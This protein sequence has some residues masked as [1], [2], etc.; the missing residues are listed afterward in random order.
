MK[1]GTLFATPPGT[2]W[3]RWIC[4][5]LGAS[6]FHWGIVIGPVGDDFMVSESLGKGTAI[7]R[8]KGRKA[9]FFKIKGLPELSP[10][11][12]V[13][14]HSRYGDYRYD[15]DVFLSTAI[16]W[17]LKHYLGKAIPVIHDDEVHCQEWTVLFGSDHCVNI[18]PEEEY[19][20]CTNLEHSPFLEEI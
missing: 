6:T 12:I 8:L 1:P 9:R 16:W 10:I 13:K 17:L 20:T 15:Y 14:W 11:D 2:W 5:V 18:I 7:C 4:R 19:P 3:A